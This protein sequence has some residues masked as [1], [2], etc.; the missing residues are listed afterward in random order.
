MT[1]PALGTNLPGPFGVD[2]GGLLSVLPKKT[3]PRPGRVTGDRINPDGGSRNV[4]AYRLLL[5]PMIAMAFLGLLFG[6][7]SPNGSEDEQ[8]FLF[9]FEAG[10]QGWV[11]EG[12]DLDDPP[13]AWEIT[14]SDSMATD[15]SQ[16]FRYYLENY[17]DQG[18]I[19]LRR[20]FEV[21]PHS[22]WRVEIS[23]EMATR[24]FGMA[25]L[26]T[27]IAGALPAAPTSPSE[28]PFQGHTGN[29]HDEDVG[30]VWLEKSYED[31]VTAGSD[32]LIHVMIGFWGTWETPRT[33][34]VDEVGIRL[35]PI[36]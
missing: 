23:Y 32:G 33:Y 24:D 15:G 4:K 27:I 30:W 35:I 2:A 13:V 21:G 14:R 34:Y 31:M 36:P 16:S 9:S 22:S 20:P 3:W 8:S 29:G 6:A 10:A 11:A 28:L 26:W 7:C 12:I 5:L 1:S 25:N 19:W 17:N 18:K